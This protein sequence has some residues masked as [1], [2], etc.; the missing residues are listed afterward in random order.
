MQHRS[1]IISRK[2]SPSPHR[3]SPSPYTSSSPSPVPFSSEI[4]KGTQ[5]TRAVSWEKELGHHKEIRR[6]GKDLCN[7]LPALSPSPE[8][9]PLRP[10][11]PPVARKSASK[12]GRSPSPY[13]SPAR[14]R[15]EQIT[16]DGSLSP[17]KQRGRKPLKD[18]PETRKDHEETGHTREGGDYYSRS[19]WKRSIHP[20]NINKQKDSPVK[21]HYKDEQSSERLAGRQTT[22]SRNYPDNRIRGRK[23]RI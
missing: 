18:S 8:R 9:S 17:Q 14:Q 15:K 21:V 6:I 19:S 16:R 3:Q 7:R 10:E 11:S 22:D 13:E 12:D 1:S 23:T 4:S 2:R 20:S 5:I